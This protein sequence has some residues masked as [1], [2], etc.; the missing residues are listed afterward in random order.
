MSKSAL[1]AGLA[2][3]LA[4]GGCTPGGL[5][6]AGG[7]DAGDTGSGEAGSSAPEDSGAQT[8]TG[9]L[10]AANKAD[11]L[12]VINNSGSMAEKQEQ[13]VQAMPE[14]I[15]PLEAADVDYRLGFTTTDVGNPWCETAPLA[16]GALQDRACTQR[17]DAFVK[18]IPDID[19]QVA[20]TAACSLDEL[21]LQKSAVDGSSELRV[22]PWLEA[23]NLPPGVSMRDAVGCLLPQGVDGCD[24]EAPLESMH[25]ALDRFEDP[26]DPSFGFRR[27]DAV[28]TVVFLTDE[29]D[30]SH[31]SK[32]E[33]VFSLEG[34]QHF[35]PDPES[36]FPSSAICWN[37]GVECL[38][39]PSPYDDC[40]SADKDVDGVPTDASG[41]V[42]HSVTR[43]QNRLD[44]LP[45]P[46]VV[47]GLL[48]VPLG[49]LDGVPLV[50]ADSADPSIQ[51]SFG[52]GYGC[53]GE[54]GGAVPP[55]RLRELQ[56]SQ[57]AETL[58]GSICAQNYDPTLSA[59]AQAILERT[60]E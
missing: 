34:N 21:L 15:A 7:D 28:F 43:Y 9:A 52:I 48:G 53:S 32:W 30:C 42:L 8:T 35:W 27:D 51:S 49:Y 46:T 11:I 41:A 33:E 17:L 5:P 24:F 36:P 26:Q 2:G 50:Y 47:A 19:A 22:R 12:F 45:Q 59:I 29:A 60:E 23:G 13:L 55:V 10:T 4:W 57:T 38:G 58:L 1:R 39:G 44:L 40:R 3:T 20:C 56:H 18:E 14:L 37:A 25:R 16:P 54:N 6:G 31:Q